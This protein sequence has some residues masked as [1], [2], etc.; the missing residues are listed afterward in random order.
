MCS[1]C[2]SAIFQLCCSI[3][4]PHLNLSI[5]FLDSKC[6]QVDFTDPFQHFVCISVCL[7]TVRFPWNYFLAV[8]SLWKCSF[9][10]TLLNKYFSSQSQLCNTFETTLVC[11]LLQDKVG[12]LIFFILFHFPLHNVRKIRYVSTVF[13]FDNNFPFERIWD[14]LISYQLTGARLF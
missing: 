9:I 5:W 14:I 6:G 4:Q 2:Y 3:I 13:R 10:C 1:F 7:G 12:Y 8:R 11:Y